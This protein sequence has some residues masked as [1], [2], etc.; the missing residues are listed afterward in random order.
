MRPDELPAAVAAAVEVLAKELAERPFVAP[1]V[2][3]LRELGLGKA[4]LAAAVRAGRLLKVADGLVLLPDACE[5]AAKVLAAIEQ[6]FTVSQARQALG[7]T[8]R[9]AVP[10]LELLD[11]LG[12]TC[13]HGYAERSCLVDP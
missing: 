6:P 4:E 5:R 13:L 11:R 10:L 1:D 8:R 2:P 7:T 12:I 3:R 9:V